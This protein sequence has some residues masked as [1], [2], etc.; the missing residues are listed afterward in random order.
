MIINTDL[1]IKTW[2]KNDKNNRSDFFIPKSEITINQIKERPKINIMTPKNT[3][4]NFG[5]NFLPIPVTPSV[6]G[7][8]QI[9]FGM[10]PF[11]KNTQAF[12]TH[13]ESSGRK[14]N[15]GGF[16]AS[17][18]TSNNTLR[19]PFASFTQL[20]NSVGLNKL[21]S[22][23]TLRGVFLEATPRSA[24]DITPNHSVFRQ[25]KYNQQERRPRSPRGF[26]RQG[27][28]FSNFQTIREE[29]ENAHTQEELEIKLVKYKLI[30]NESVEDRSV[31][32]GFNNYKISKGEQYCR[33]ELI[34]LQ[35]N[36]RNHLETI[37][38][39]GWYDNYIITPHGFETKVQYLD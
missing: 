28:H 12:H 5:P 24:F 21:K 2:N 30:L 15:L 31:V 13:S 23:S 18:K 20:S 9:N 32:S 4:Y 33:D 26:K 27:S 14:T 3:S 11:T 22:Q 36:S 1:N 19:Q 17:T 39:L 16:T 25:E 29:S 8:H 7:S 37:K 38:K 35:K 6:L 34:Q 10:S